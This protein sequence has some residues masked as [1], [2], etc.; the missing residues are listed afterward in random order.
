MDVADLK[1]CW[2]YIID[3]KLLQALTKWRIEKP[4]L[5]TNGRIIK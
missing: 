3:D 5:A 2:L 4:T 1:D